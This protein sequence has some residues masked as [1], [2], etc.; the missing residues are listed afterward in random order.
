MGLKRNPITVKEAVE[1]VMAHCTFLGHEKVVLEHAYGR[2][3]AEPII[4]TNDVPPF[5]RS[6]YDGYAIRSQDTI[7]ASRENP[8]LLN[9]LGTVAAGKVASQALGEK[10]AYRI[11]TGAILPEGADAIVMLEHTEQMERGILVKQAY[12]PGDN[13]SHQGEDAKRGETLITAGKTIH[14]GT[15]A[16]LAT[17][18]YHEVTVGKKPR[19][20]VISTGTEL[21]RVDAELEPG[22]IRD[23]NGPM[24][25]AQLKRLGIQAQSLGLTADQPEAMN[26][27]LEQALATSDVVVTTG[28]VSVGDFDYLP[29]M[30]RRLGAR[31]LFNKVKMRPGSVTTVATVNDKLLFGL[32][33]NPSACF[34]GFELFVRPALMKMQGSTAP[35]LPRMR[36]VLG[37]DFPQANPFTRFVR[38]LWYMTEAGP[39][40][41]SAGFNKSNA[42][43]SI[44]RGNCIIVLPSGSNGYKK[45]EKV[46]I[47]LLGQ[48]QGIA[49]WDLN[50]QFV[51]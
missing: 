29:E 31:V 32:S 12:Q 40:A 41:V 30:Y 48:D 27:L 44:A 1:R 43:A 6:A 28:G 16:L 51:G 35:Y 33:G 17:F 11:M 7:D 46:D 15:I 19:V 21:L 20:S 2:V 26:T 34:T 8:V 9:V 25:M 24:L 14:P 5:N 49:N 13:V 4:A 42:I 39:V 50:E 45:G 38:A 22:K 47:L 3:L 36:A 10:E 18:G 37:E 23:S